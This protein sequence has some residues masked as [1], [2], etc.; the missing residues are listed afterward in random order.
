MAGSTK[1]GLAALSWFQALVATAML[2]LLIALGA[3]FIL[4]ERAW[5]LCYQKLSEKRPDDWQDLLDS[6]PRYVVGRAFG[7]WY[8]KVART[9]DYQ[10]VAGSVLLKQP[11]DEDDELRNL[12]LSARK[13]AIRAFLAFL[14]LIALCPTMVVLGMTT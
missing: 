12:R 8:D 3:A 11:S 13:W 10:E 7:A 1:W 4:Y 9:L 6:S 2:S 14:A 5:R